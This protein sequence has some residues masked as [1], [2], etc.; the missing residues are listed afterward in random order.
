M[1]KKTSMHGNY[2]VRVCR[3]TNGKG[4]K[5]DI[6]NYRTKEKTVFDIDSQG[7]FM[8]RDRNNPGTKVMERAIKIYKELV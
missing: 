4:G 5:I 2:V 6:E 8:Q 3:V 1:K 7:T